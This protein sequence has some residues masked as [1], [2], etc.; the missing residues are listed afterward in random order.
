MVHVALCAWVGNG[1][2][3]QVTAPDARTAIA[4]T[5][6]L[7]ALGTSSHIKG[8]SLKRECTVTTNHL[9]MK[10]LRQAHTMSLWGP[11][12]HKTPT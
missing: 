12:A 1:R 6:L 3:M 8:L 7:T 4:T 9:L 10:P 2:C 5:F 11:H